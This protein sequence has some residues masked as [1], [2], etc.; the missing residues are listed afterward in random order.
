FP[1]AGFQYQRRRESIS[2]ASRPSWASNTPQCTPASRHRT[3]TY[4][5]II[6]LSIL[7]PWF[8][9]GVPPHYPRSG[10]NGEEA[11]YGCQS[12]QFAKGE[13]N[14]FSYASASSASPASSVALSSSASNRAITRV[15]LGVRSFALSVFRAVPSA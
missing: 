15:T 8:G 9:G 4:F 7:F 3:M 10:G 5:P 6:P 12:G 11:P 14:P 13:A 2:S 1:F